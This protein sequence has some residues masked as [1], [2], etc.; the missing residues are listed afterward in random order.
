VYEEDDKQVGEDVDSDVDRRDDDRYRL[1]G[2]YV[3]DPNRVDELL[4]DARVAEEELRH[5]DSTDQVLDVLGEDLNARRER[6][7][8]GVSANDLPFAKA[9]QAGHLHVIG[10]ERLDHPRAHHPDRGRERHADQREHGEDQHLGIAERALTGW[11]Q[12][13]GRQDVQPREEEQDQERSDN[14]LRKRDDRQRR[15]RDAVVER[16]ACTHGSGDAEEERQ[17]NHDHG[18]DQGQHEGV[19]ELAL[20]LAPH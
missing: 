8:Q 15:D 4:S 16:A 20:D 6:V 3:P 10:L 12:G 13:Y 19:G 14:K 7:A 9:V 1:H 5:D 17:R 18:R 2:A 11:D